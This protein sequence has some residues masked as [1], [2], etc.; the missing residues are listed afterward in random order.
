[1]GREWGSRDDCFGTTESPPPLELNS[2][3]LDSGQDRRVRGKGLRRRGERNSEFDSHWS[4]VPR[5]TP[6]DP[7]DGVE[8]TLSKKRSR[9]R[10]GGKDG[11]GEERKG[12]SKTYS[13]PTTWS[14]P[15]YV[16]APFSDLGV[17]PVRRPRSD[18]NGLG[19]G[20]QSSLLV[21]KRNSGQLTYKT[22]IVDSCRV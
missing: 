18:R 1:M 7:S 17:L 9:F 4:T 15:K 13:C 21:R 11:P 22:M 10:F 5:P 14:S 16:V 2:R 12:S 20:E 3:G 19:H 8:K 6:T